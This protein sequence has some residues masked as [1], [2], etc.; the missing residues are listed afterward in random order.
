MVIL[1]MCNNI[2]MDDNIVMGN[3]KRWLL[4]MAIAKSDC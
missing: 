3:K 4:I 1:V 2:V